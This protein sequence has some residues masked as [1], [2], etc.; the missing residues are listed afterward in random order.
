[1]IIRS[2]P[3]GG[4][5][6]AAVKSFYANIAINGNFVLDTKN[7]NKLKLLNIQSE[8]TH[9]C[10]GTPSQRNPNWLKTEVEPFIGCPATEYSSYSV[11]DA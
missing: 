8:T 7:S 11:G 4:N 2:S 6:F 9:I 5:F 10:M 1:M 3:I